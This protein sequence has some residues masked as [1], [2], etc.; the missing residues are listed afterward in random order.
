MQNK[1]KSIAEYKQYREMFRYLGRCDNALM[2]MAIKDKNTSI[3]NKKLWKQ[4]EKWEANPN[5]ELTI[6]QRLRDSYY[7]CPIEFRK[8]KR[9]FWRNVVSEYRASL[10]LWWSYNIFDLSANGKRHP[11]KKRIRLL[12]ARAN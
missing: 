8:T 9:Q 10:W 7:N 6:Y 5:K 1:W 2:E 12:N 3:N 4:I 11:F